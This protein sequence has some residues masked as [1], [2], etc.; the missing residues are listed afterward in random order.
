MNQ[1]TATCPDWF[2]YP[3]RVEI[4]WNSRPK[5]S[6]THKGKKFQYPLRVEIDWNTL[7]MADLKPSVLSFST[8]CGSK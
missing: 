7:D 6:L 8:L 1:P 3:L 5:S 4:D 2:Q